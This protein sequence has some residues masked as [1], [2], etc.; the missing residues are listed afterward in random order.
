MTMGR[1][2]L[3]KKSADEIKMMASQNIA[4]DMIANGVAIKMASVLARLMPKQCLKARICR[5]H[6]Q[7]M[8]IMMVIPTG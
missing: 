4:P 5:A 8:H 3:Y 6:D 1:V 7:P 2:M